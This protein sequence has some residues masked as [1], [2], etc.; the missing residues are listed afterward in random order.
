MFHICAFGG[1]GELEPGTQFYFTIFGG[2]ERRRPTLA[3]MIAWQRSGERLGGMS[4]FLTLFG[5]VEVRTP[6]LAEEYSELQA[7]LRSGAFTLAEVERVLSSAQTA[8]RTGRITVFGYCD[9]AGLPTEDEELDGL[10]LLRHT[11]TLSSA[12]EQALV[13]GIGRAGAHRVGIL[14]AALQA[15]AA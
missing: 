1:G 7:G 14:R 8:F 2:T 6:T 13:L 15:R 4:F 11:G 3:K 5:G 9:T 12:G 10:A